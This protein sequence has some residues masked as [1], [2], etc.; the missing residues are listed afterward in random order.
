MSNRLA[1]VCVV[2]DWHIY[3]HVPVPYKVTYCINHNVAF[4]SF[5]KMLNIT[6]CWSYDKQLM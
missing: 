3:I 6:L 1:Y 5:I 2:Q 4:V